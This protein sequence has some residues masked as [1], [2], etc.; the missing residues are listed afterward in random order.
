MRKIVFALLFAQLLSFSLLA[1][2][3]DTTWVTIWNLRKITQ[4]GNHD[5][6]AVLPSGKTYRKIRMH[7]ILGRYACPSGTQYC[8][9]WDYTTK[10]FALPPASDTVE[11]A[12]VITP[13]AT[14]WINTN[15]TH[16]FV[17][18]VTDYAS[19]LKGNLDFRYVYEGYSWGFTLTLKLELIEGTPA[20]EA[21]SVQNI[22]N[23]YYTYGSSTNL[24]ENHLTEKTFQYNAPATKS[25]VKNIISGHG[26]D[27]NDCSEFCSKYYQLKVNG[28]VTSQK[29]LWKSDCGLNDIFPQ[30]GTWLFERANWCPGQEVYPIKH[31]ITSLTSPA[32]TFSLDIDMEPYIGPTQSNLGGYSIASQLITYANPSFLTDVSIEDIVAPTVDPNYARANAICANPKV[33]IKNVGT[34]PLTQV[35]FNYGLVGA[36]SY[37]YSWVGNLPFLKDTIIDFGASLPLYNGNPTNSF[38]VGIVSVNGTNGD[39]NLFNNSY[40]STYNSVKVYPNQFLVQFKANAS[41]SG[42]NASLSETSW[43][44][45]DDLGNI[46]YSR[47][48]V[49]VNALIRDTVTLPDGCYTFTMNDESCDGI[50]WWAYQYYNPNPGNGYIRFTKL[51]SVPLVLKNFNGDFGCQI[52]ERFMTS[53]VT[54]V[55]DYKKLEQVQLYP[56]PS[57]EVVNLLFS[58]TSFQDITYTITDVTGKMLKSDVLN[59]VGSDAYP[60]SVSDLPNGMY[61]INCQ[62]KDNPTS[63]VIKFVINR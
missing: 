28:V 23:G 31:D 32:T 7:Y 29:Q 26:A 8:G 12:R 44:I 45:K 50:S 24:I 52:T 18:D 47:L 34:N 43:T 40:H 16:D 30:T 35:V 46:V 15:R 49:P 59:H 37:T 61:Y 14:D 25:V 1:N 55:M 10:V 53:S 39:E 42:S 57:N 13:Y 2:P 56:N 51:G 54:S 60:I 63:Q 22:Y 38:S 36:T 6:S 5:T 27:D 4:Y 33:K 11:M 17:I 58:L 41:A 21:L 19:I 20:M 3:G 48:N 62:F 9:S